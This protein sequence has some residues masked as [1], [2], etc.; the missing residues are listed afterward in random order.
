MAVMNANS[1][2]KKLVVNKPVLSPYTL[3]QIRLSKADKWQEKEL[4]SKI[5]S[6][7]YSQ[8]EIRVVLYG[9]GQ[10]VESVNVNSCQDSTILL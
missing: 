7:F 2:Y 9:Q 4:L 5:N 8:A 10:Y 3:W 1:S 6:L